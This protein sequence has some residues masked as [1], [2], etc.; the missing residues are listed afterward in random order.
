MDAGTV[1][2]VARFGPASVPTTL[3]LQSD[4]HRDYFGVVD[5]QEC[6]GCTARG[7]ISVQSSSTPEKVFTP[8][9]AARIVQP[10]DFAALSIN[11]G[12]IRS[13][14][15]IAVDAGERQILEDGRSTVLKSNNVIH[16]G[17]GCTAEGSRQY[18][19]RPCSLPYLADEICVQFLRLLRRTLE[20]TASFRLHHG[21]QLSDVDVTVK[22]GLLI[23]GQLS[24][25]SQ[26]GEFVHARGVTIP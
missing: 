15:A 16:L 23:F 5:A 25:T 10:N 26:I 6:N 3:F 18:S 7:R 21:P 17:A 8:D 12:N 9:V 4:S 14:E 11:S 22:F 20:G 13:F 19:H 2:G 1:A 24:L